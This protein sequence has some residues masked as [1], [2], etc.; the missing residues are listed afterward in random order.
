MEYTSQ[1]CVL[2]V[3]GKDLVEYHEKFSKD[4]IDELKEK[5]KKY[6]ETN[7]SNKCDKKQ[8]EKKFLKVNN[9]CE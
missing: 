6:L 5:L 2:K 8:F 9:I 1:Y 4:K 3:L 7:Y